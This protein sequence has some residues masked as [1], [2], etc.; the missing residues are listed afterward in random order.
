[1]NDVVLHHC[2]HRDFSRWTLS[3]LQDLVLSQR[4]AETEALGDELDTDSG[5]AGDLMRQRLLA[6]IEKR[7]LTGHK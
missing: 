2:R 7:Y 6:D 5:S 3:A 4:L 1:M